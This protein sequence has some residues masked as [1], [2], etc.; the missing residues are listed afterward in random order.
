MDKTVLAKSLC[1]LLYTNYET[2]F[3]PYGKK[4][5]YRTT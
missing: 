3:S 1:L 4:D 2:E 5:D